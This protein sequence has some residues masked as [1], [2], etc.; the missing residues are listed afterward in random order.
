MI[1]HKLTFVNTFDFNTV[2]YAEAI[3]MALRVLGYKTVVEAKGTWPTN[4]IAKAEELDLLEDITYGTYATGAKRGNVAL[5][6]WNMLREEMW[7]VYAESEGDGL[8]YGKSETMLNKKFKDY[9]YFTTTFDSYAIGTDAEIT[10][11]VGGVS[12]DSYEYTRPDFYTYVPGSEVEVL[13]NIKD[14]VLLS[15]VETDEYK[16]L[17]GGKE[18]IDEEYDEARYN[19]II[20][21]VY[22]YAFT[23]IN[24]KDLQQS[25]QIRVNSTYVYELDDSSEK[26]LKVNGGKISSLVYDTFENNVV[27][28]DGEFASVKDLEVGDVWSVVTVD[29]SGDYVSAAAPTFYMI[30]G[31]EDEGKLTKLVEESFDRPTSNNTYYVATIDGEELNVADNAI[32]F[33]D[34]DDEDPATKG[35]LAEDATTHKNMKNE[36]VTYVTDF[37]GRVVAVTFDGKLNEG[38]ESDESD[39]ANFYALLGAVER[40]GSTY[41]IKVATEDGEE[42]LTFAKN[43]G[44][45]AWINAV[46]YSGYFVIMTLNEDGEIE[47]LSG[48]NATTPVEFYVRA[49]MSGDTEVD[50]MDYTLVYDDEN[51]Y[52]TVSGE[53]DVTLDGNQLLDSGENLITKVN[54]DTVVVTLVHDVKD[55]DD[56]NDDEYTVEFAGIEA[57]E[58]MKDDNAIIITDTS[59]SNFAAAK[60]VVI[61]DSIASREDDL[62][63]IVKD[64]YTNRLDKEIITLVEDRDDEAK[65]GVEYILKS[66]V[67]ESTDQWVIYS[68]EED[69]DGNWELTGRFVLTNAMLESGDISKVTMYIDVTSGD[70][71]SNVSTDGREAILYTGSRLDLDAEL[72][73]DKYEEARVFI[74]NVSLDEDVSDTQYYVDN[75]T[76]VDYAAL[77]LEEGDR[78]VEVTVGSDVSELVVIRGMD[79]YVAPAAQPAA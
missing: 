23:L 4:Y 66:G 59:A 11:H 71:N 36:V 28:K 64:V 38:G 56:A 29:Y 69:K 53:L 24:G 79:A 60:Y 70:D 27:L 15:M 32:Y 52:Y 25:T 57:I 31:A 45:A 43:K 18:T 34:A 2:S 49:N 46:D 39:E 55:E 7:D 77:K 26:R 74:V 65:D 16:Y 8:T 30:S 54:A 37:L 3:T 76:E 41:T 33:V 19:A 22:H 58:N 21:D 50:A 12:G 51:H 35:F 9:R 75:Y 47:T 78:I 42:E 13:L 63:G 44:N 10:V 6:I 61:F 14:D 20:D 48:D 1:F 62:V 5:L 17:A 40:D 67:T 72:T 73:E 68:I